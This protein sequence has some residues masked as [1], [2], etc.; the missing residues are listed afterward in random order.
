MALAKIDLRSAVRP[1]A[2]R[3]NLLAQ[4]G[5]GA[6]RR[7][8]QQPATVPHS[9][10]DPQKLRRNRGFGAERLSAC[11]RRDQGIQGRSSLSTWLPRVVVA[12]TIGRARAARRHAS[13]LIVALELY[14]EK[15]MPGSITADRPDAR[16]LLGHRL[17]EKD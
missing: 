7:P 9:L 17:Q 14:R 13:R 6:A 12:E 10:V 11:L 16:F 3:V 1:S 4:L 8:A 2:R 15:F 5:S